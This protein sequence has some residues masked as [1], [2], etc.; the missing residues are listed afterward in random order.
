MAISAGAPRLW[1]E[2][3]ARVTK[4]FALVAGV[5]AFWSAAACKDNS[6]RNVTRSDLPALP[7][8]AMEDPA[9]PREG[10]PEV[11]CDSAMDDWLMALEN[12]RDTA[13]LLEEQDCTVHAEGLMLP[14]ENGS[15]MCRGLWGTHETNAQIAVILED[16]KKKACGE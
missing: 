11:D 14:S 5:V 16:A 4:F 9:P 10:S 15:P 2:R 13:E 6:A 1:R 3:A 7:S 8:Q 12:L